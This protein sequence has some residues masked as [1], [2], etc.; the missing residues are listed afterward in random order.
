VVRVELGYRERARTFIAEQHAQYLA[1][2][3]QPLAQAR[4]EQCVWAF[5]LTGPYA[6]AL[7]GA[8]MNVTVRISTS[9]P[10][11][12]AVQLIFAGREVLTLN[13]ATRP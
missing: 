13:R 6:P 9:S 5:L 12:Q 11:L 2:C 8:S 3:L 7:V 10:K 1:A 4:V